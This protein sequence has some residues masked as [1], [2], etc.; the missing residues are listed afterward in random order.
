[1]KWYVILQRDGNIKN[2][3]PLTPHGNTQHYFEIEAERLMDAERLAPAA[4]VAYWERVQA[5]APPTRVPARTYPLGVTRAKNKPK[6]VRC[7]CGMPRASED[8]EQC[9]LCDEIDRSKPLP[10]IGKG[11]PRE[12]KDNDAVLIALLEV[13]RQWQQSPNVGLFTKWLGHRI[14]MLRGVR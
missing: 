10:L 4:A 12:S 13:Q 1:M 14:A 8:A 5:G 2:V 11:E 7:K 9:L 3:V 6:A